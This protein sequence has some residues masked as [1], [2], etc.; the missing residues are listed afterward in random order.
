VFVVT[1]AL[2]AANLLWVWVTVP[3][4]PKQPASDGN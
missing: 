1:A 3:E 4:L 2:L